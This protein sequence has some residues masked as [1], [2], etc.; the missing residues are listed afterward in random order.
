VRHPIPLTLTRDRVW[1]SD[2]LDQLRS[3]SG[4]AYFLPLGRLGPGLYRLWIDGL[5]PGASV[6]A[7]L[8][9]ADFELVDHQGIARAGG[10]RFLSFRVAAPAELYLR[11]RAQGPL[12]LTRVELVVG[13]SGGTD[14]E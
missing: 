4:T 5:D 13:G 14:R 12:A 3:P 8:M 6:C 7:E 10:R 2:V 9:A 1:D 11:I